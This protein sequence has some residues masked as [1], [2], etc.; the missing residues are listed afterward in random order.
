M[1]R[2]PLGG[3]ACV[4][5][6]FHFRVEIAHAGAGTIVANVFH[7]QGKRAQH[8]SQLFEFLCYALVL[9]LVFL[10][11]SLLLPQ[12]VHDSINHAAQ[13]FAALAVLLVDPVER[14][15]CSLDSSLEVSYV[16]HTEIIF[17]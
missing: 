4:T 7:S 16:T 11:F 8:A 5:Q 3:P 12:A 15:L 1:L 10:H 13:V 17:R 2:R 9:N 14:L 6:E